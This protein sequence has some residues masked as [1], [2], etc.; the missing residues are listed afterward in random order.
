MG[1]NLWSLDPLPPSG[2]RRHDIDEDIG[3]VDHNKMAL[4]TN[5]QNLHLIR[6]LH[7]IGHRYALDGSIVTLRDVMRD[8]KMLRE[9]KLVIYNA[10]QSYLDGSSSKA[11]VEASVKQIK[12]SNAQFN[13]FW[14]SLDYFERHG[15]AQ[16][17][18]HYF[19][20]FQTKYRNKRFWQTHYLTGV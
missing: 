7:M 11:D 10:I 5:Y 13:A 17:F 6:H 8:R 12:M 14:Q 16:W 9:R 19:G 20:Q 3:S 4:V 2:W 18:A 15:E 1:T